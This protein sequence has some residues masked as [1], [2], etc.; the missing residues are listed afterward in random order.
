MRRIYAARRDALAA[1]LRRH[2]GGAV[3]F[4]VPDGGMALWVRADDGINVAAWA[5]TSEREGVLFSDSRQYDFFHRAQPFLRLGF[6]Y[7]D[8][9]EL[10]EAVRRMARA[11]VKVGRARRGA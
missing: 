3:D 5:H 2:L 7:H 6:T 10:E 11:L 4:Q 1:G 9:S 8:E